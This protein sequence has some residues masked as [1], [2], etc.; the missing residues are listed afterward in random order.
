[1][2]LTSYPAASTRTAAKISSDVVRASNAIDR[3]MAAP[4]PELCWP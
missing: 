2:V 3:T 1:M 4:A